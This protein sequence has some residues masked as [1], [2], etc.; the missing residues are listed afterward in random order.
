MRES[1]R[2]R[3][4]DI[5]TNLFLSTCLSLALSLCPLGLSR[6]LSLSLS[7]LFSQPLYPTQVIPPFVFFFPPL[8]VYFSCCL[9]L[10]FLLFSLTPSN[11]FSFKIFLSLSFSHTHSLTRS[12]S[13]HLFLSLSLSLSLSSPTEPLRPPNLNEG[14]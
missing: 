12:D 7:L 2:N 9:S 1:P 6:S 3:S 13:N 4:C 11:T 14:E 10:L 5:H 8:F